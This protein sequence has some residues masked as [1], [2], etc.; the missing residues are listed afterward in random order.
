[1]RS[2]VRNPQNPALLTTVSAHLA[3]PEIFFPT[4][5]ETKPIQTSLP[6]PS[7][8]PSILSIAQL[9]LDSTSSLLSQLLLDLEHHVANLVHLESH[10]H[11]LLQ[12]YSTQPN[13]PTLD[14]ELTRLRNEWNAC[15]VRCVDLEY[16]IDIAVATLKHSLDL[17]I[18]L[19]PL[20]SSSEELSMCDRGGMEE[21]EATV[22]ELLRL[23]DT[24]ILKNT[25]LSFE[26]LTEDPEKVFSLESD[27]ISLIREVVQI[28]EE[29]AEKMATRVSHV[30][31]L[32]AKVLHS[33]DLSTAQK[34][35]TLLLKGKALTLTVPFAQDTEEV[36]STLRKAIKLDSNL[37]DAWCELGEYEW[38]TSGPESAL[39]LL[40]TAFKLDLPKETIVRQNFLT[41]AEF[42]NFVEGCDDGGV[43]VSLRFAHAAVRER[44][45]SGQAW[46]CLGNALFTASLVDAEGGGFL[47]RSLVAFAQAAKYPEVVGQPHF[48]FNRAAAMHYADNFSGALAHWFRAALLDPAWPAPRI[49]AI[50]CLNALRKMHTAVHATGTN[51]TT[52]TTRKRVASLISTLS[53]STNSMNRLLGPY[54]S[55]RY[56]T[57]AELAEGSN[58]GVVCCGGIVASLPADS[59]LTLNLLLVD[60]KGAF[61]VLRIF[62]I[63]KG[64]GPSTK[65]VIAIP[66]PIVEHCTV[67]TGLI[68]LLHA[69]DACVRAEG[70]ESA[71]EEDD[72]FGGRDT[73]IKELDQLES[74]DFLIL[75]VSS[76]QILCVNG[77]RVGRAW[78][79][80]AVPKNVFFAST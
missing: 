12:L 58:P 35:R 48:H 19:T 27:L 18:L 67:S 33:H 50:R 1:M 70:A 75:R 40:Q 57:F 26:N 34:A 5:C 80:A 49:N 37:S 45:D 20:F 55:L 30:L 76:P 62:Q 22:D 23:R 7:K 63:G 38:M 3:S 73:K 65:D 66:D 24:W 2:V 16:C 56:Q 47:S 54:H 17:A 43:A 6:P 78:T 72:E 31:D 71:E 44:P 4:F 21:L 42:S 61:L 29:K 39:P 41:S 32:V 79:A 64:S 9:Q 53:P 60:A 77:S 69:F 25:R 13:N 51:T 68:H 28:S 36:K 15:V 59:E 8:L 74:L 11:Q 10:Q 46:E 14:D 52:K